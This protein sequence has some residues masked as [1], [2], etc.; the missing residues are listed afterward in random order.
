MQRKK[1]GV[2]FIG[3]E[4]PSEQR[5]AQICQDADLI[6]AAD[7]G[8][9]K[10]LDSGVVPAA[11]IGDMDS[12]TSAIPDGIELEH[13][14]IDK[15]Y[16]DTELGIAWLRR[17]GMQNIV[18]IGGGGGRMDHLF[19]IMTLFWL[20]NP[21]C[22]WY[23]AQDELIFVRESMSIVAPLEQIVSIFA[24]PGK[25]VSAKSQGLFWPLDNLVL[26]TSHLSLS[27]R[28]IAKQVQ[29]SVLSGAL[30]FLRNLSDDSKIISFKAKVDADS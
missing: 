11:V 27:N 14:P 5:V 7:G 1:W 20:P 2:L 18:L 6:A 15:D 29:L 10:A 23:T 8:L 4:G 13:H 26:D 21:P 24:I 28:V 3:G 16:S 17:K 12:F 9:Q 30:L 25:P 22:R 19:A